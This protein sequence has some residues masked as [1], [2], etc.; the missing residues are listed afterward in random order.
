M[1]KNQ[2]DFCA[3]AT[4]HLDNYTNRGFRK[5]L[6]KVK[7]IYQCICNNAISGYVWQN[8]QKWH[9]KP[10]VSAETE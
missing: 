10:I 7:N 1:Q 9:K 5:E 8:I 4:K 2:I 3:K 6:T